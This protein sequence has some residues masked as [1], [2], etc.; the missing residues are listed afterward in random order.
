MYQQLAKSETG[1]LVFSPASIS[2]AIS[3]LEAGAHGETLRQID[4]T[5]RFSLGKT[6]VQDAFNALDQ[7]LA[8]PRHAADGEKRTPLKLEQTDAV[9]GQRGHGF[10]RGFLDLLAHDYGAGLRLADFAKH[11]EA[12]RLKINAY[13]ANATHEK[14]KELFPKGIIDGL[15]RM[16]L[17]NAIT[18][19]GDWVTPFDPN[20]QPASFTRLDGSTVQAPLMTN[21]EASCALRATNYD[22]VE[23][24]YIGGASMIVIAPN[25]GEFATVEHQFGTAMFSALDRAPQSIH[26]AVSMPKFN[27]ASQFSLNGTLAA[28]GVSDAFNAN[29][30]D[31]SGI[32]GKPGDLYVKDVVHQATI[33]V[34]EKGTEAAAATGDVVELSDLPPTIT[35]DHPFL[36][37]IRDDKTGAIL[38]TGRVLD[39]TAR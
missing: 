22:A 39:P 21:G 15:T 25:A 8:A 4:A 17:V 13:V 16:V 32:G 14:I 12:E 38:F 10:E 19:K 5:L 31:L 36:F 9:W 1:N 18:F 11:A 27:F 2:N 28:M 3:M 34:D 33:K 30:A 24:P 20:S 37:A 29:R 26:Y 7:M 6:R 23:I 35:I